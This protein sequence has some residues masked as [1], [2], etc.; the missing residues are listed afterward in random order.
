MFYPGFY[1]RVY[2][3]S[4]NICD[5]ENNDENENSIFILNKSDFINF[6]GNT[7]SETLDTLFFVVL[8]RR[9]KLLMTPMIMLAHNLDL[10]LSNKCPEVI[11]QCKDL[12]LSHLIYRNFCTITFNHLFNTTKSRLHT[13]FV[14]YLQTYFV[15]FLI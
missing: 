15:S 2:D 10:A 8:Y 1:A 4:F 12:L 11:I 14:S 3:I 7:I 13:N 9:T 6:C 5:F